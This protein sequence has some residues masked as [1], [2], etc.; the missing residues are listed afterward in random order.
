MA[1]PYKA[2]GRG[3]G[4]SVLVRAD[5]DYYEMLG[6]PRGADKKT[7]KSAYRT[8]ARKYHP[9][10]NK[11]AGAEDTFK[12]I[13]E[14]YEVLSDENK[15][16]IY[17][18][19]GEAGLKGGM[20]GFGGA[21]PMD[22]TN[23]FELF[24]SFFGGNFGGNADRSRTR[25]MAGEDQRYELQLEF[26]DA[27]FGAAKEI[28]VGRLVQCQTCTGSGQK[29]GTTPT[30]C[31]QCAGQ[32]QLLSSMRTPLGTFQQ[33]TSCPR[34]DG[35]GQMFTACDTCGGDG[36]VRSF[37]KISLRVPPGVDTDSRLRVRG[38]GNA[39]MRGGESGDL[40]VFIVVKEHPELRREGTTIHSEVD[41]SYLDAILG[42]TVKVTTVDGPVELK[43]PPGTQPG[44]TLL[45]TKRG[46]PRLGTPS[47]RGDHQVHVRV[48]IPKRLKS[49]EQRLVEQLRELQTQKV[50]AK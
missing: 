36:R 23:P 3:R 20:G 41:V 29:P 11:E 33:V 44:T 2:A 25:P 45:M 26:L 16:A 12:K 31:V 35:R 10:V 32:G 17:D 8:K 47:S 37:K 34:C 46:V 13:G 48:V 14:A 21:S 24:E 50:A 49:E 1:R 6:V 38:E 7:I 28:E 18:K 30:S 42:T 15:R 9:D 22:F 27:V 4:W 19:Y 5:T 40:Y 39:G 43:I